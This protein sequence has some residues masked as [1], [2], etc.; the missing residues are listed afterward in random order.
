MVMIR[1]KGKIFHTSVLWN[2]VAIKYQWKMSLSADI[3]LLFAE[4][5]LK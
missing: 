2:V 1:H 3:N 4:G 5:K